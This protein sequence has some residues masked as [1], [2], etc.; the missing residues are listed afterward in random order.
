[1]KFDLNA[2]SLKLAYIISH[3]YTGWL[4]NGWFGKSGEG[5]I[6]PIFI[7]LVCNLLWALFGGKNT[8]IVG[9]VS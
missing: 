9:C 2:K 5:Q 3:M 4:K 7:I 6:Y 8:R 1:M